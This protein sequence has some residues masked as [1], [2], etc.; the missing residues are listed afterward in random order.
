MSMCR[1]FSCVVG[2]GCWLWPVH[3]LGKTLLAF[4]LLHSLLQGQICL[5][6][7][8]FLEFLLLHSSPLKW[9]GHM[10]WMSVL[11]VLVGL[12]ST[13]QLQ[14]LQH[15]WS[16]HRLGLLSY[17]MV[18]LGKE[19]RLEC[20]IIHNYSPQFRDEVDTFWGSISWV[21]VM[22]CFVMLIRVESQAFLDSI[23]WH[24]NHIVWGFPGG[25]VVKNPPSNAGDGSG[26][27]TGEGNG[28]LLPYSCQE[29]SM[30]RGDWWDTVHGVAKSRTR[31]STAEQP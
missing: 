4:T 27:S 19:Q 30:D 8:V 12:H 1:V 13:I 2:R 11:K 31:L 29:N 17:W 14:L 16:G 9:K 22:I 6:L 24:V 7:Q 20:C 10:F 26:R 3:S 21:W 23:R 5:L 15:Y 18:C 25:S 28:N